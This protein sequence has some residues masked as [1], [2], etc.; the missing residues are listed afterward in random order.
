M[1]VICK[2]TKGSEVQLG[3]C[4]HYKNSIAF[5]L[6]QG[7]TY[8]VYAQS[9][10]A[11]CLKYLIDPGTSLHT[12]RPNWYPSVW[13]TVVQDSVPSSWVFAFSPDAEDNEPFAIWGY[14]ELAHGRNHFVGLIE[15]ESDELLTFVARASEIDEELTDTDATH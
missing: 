14:P 13:F 15:R 7:A 8:T 12:R 4:G 2:A 11:G 6:V 9:L 1:K 5:E 10:V 3:L